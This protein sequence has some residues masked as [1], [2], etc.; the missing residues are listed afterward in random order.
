M[1][2]VSFSPGASARVPSA[3]STTTVAT[4]TPPRMT[5]SMRIR[6][7]TERAGRDDQASRAEHDLFGQV[8]NAPG[9]RQRRAGGVVDRDAGAPA[10][11]VGHRG[12]DRIEQPLERRGIARRGA[13]VSGSA[14]RA[15]GD[16][17]Q[18]GGAGVEAL[19]Q[20]GF[21]A[22][23][24]RSVVS[25]EARAL[26][27][28]A[29]QA[30]GQRGGE[31]GAHDAQDEGHGQTQDTRVIVKWIGSEA[32]AQA[33]RAAGGRQLADGRDSVRRRDDVPGAARGA[34][35]RRRG[36]GRACCSAATSPSCCRAACA[37]SSPPSPARCCRSRS[38]WSRSSPRSPSSCSA[39]RC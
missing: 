22:A 9:P 29:D 1:V 7:R 39:V 28:V 33:R 8:G 3:C 4:R 5:A 16:R 34:D 12:R 18:R 25:A 26:E 10:I 11:L 36:A 35:H 2:N 32:P 30:G 13:R 17:P 20:F 23:E 6:P 19:P 38:R 21:D 24:R 31:A 14:A 27:A 37:T 15:R